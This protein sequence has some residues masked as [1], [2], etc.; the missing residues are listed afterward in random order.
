MGMLQAASDKKWAELQQQ[1]G[2]L[3]VAEYSYM[4]TGRFIQLVLD[5][6]TYE[7]FEDPGPL[8]HNGRF[9][10]TLAPLSQGVIGF[11]RHHRCDSILQNSGFPL[12][13]VQMAF[14]RMM[15]IEYPAT[16]ATTTGRY[17]RYDLITGEVDDLPM[18]S[19]QARD[20]SFRTLEGSKVIFHNNQTVDDLRTRAWFQDD[21][22]KR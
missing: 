20:S 12:D 7:G 16:G 15:S 13:K 14:D 17:Y 6:S 8:V 3:M 22:V 2:Y 11:V 5:V 9:S 4:A 19:I 1:M 18:R 10:G 21:T